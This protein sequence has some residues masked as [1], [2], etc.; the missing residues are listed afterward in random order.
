MFQSNWLSL[1]N[2]MVIEVMF[3]LSVDHQQDPE[4]CLSPL[5]GPS[6]LPGLPPLLQK[7]LVPDRITLLG[8]Q[9]WNLARDAT[10]SSKGPGLS[11]GHS[12]RMLPPEQVWDPSWGEAG[13]S[14]AAGQGQEHSWACASTE[15]AKDR[16]SLH[17]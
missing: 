12:R 5:P 11:K 16:A 13:L 3:T 4:P 1:F 6:P 9:G 8:C 2:P 10:R 14:G 7:L 17:F 15:G